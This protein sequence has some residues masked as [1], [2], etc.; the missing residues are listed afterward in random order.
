M[1]ATGLPSTSR[2]K[3]RFHPN[4]GTLFTTTRPGGGFACPALL[5]EIAHTK[6]RIRRAL[7]PKLRLDLMADITHKTRFSPARR[8]ANRRVIQWLPEMAVVIP[9][10][11]TRS[12]ARMLAAWHCCREKCCVQLS[13]RWRPI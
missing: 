4:C 1:V 10:D 2:L 11:T 7:L 9:K 12:L 8:W 13:G 6:A 5:V 3:A